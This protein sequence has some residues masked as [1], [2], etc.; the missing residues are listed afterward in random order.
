[1][2]EQ[3]ARSVGCQPETV[4]IAPKAKG[5]WIGSQAARHVLIWYHGGG[6]AMS[7]NIAYFKFLAKVVDDARS[8]GKD[9]AVFLV[10]YSLAPDAQY[11]IQ[12]TQS[13]AAL[14]HIL[15]DTGRTPSQVFLGGDSAGGNLAFGVLSHLAHKCSEI[16]ELTVDEPLAGAV[17]IAP[18]TNLTVADS[19]HPGE[20]YCGGDLITPHAGRVWSRGYLGST[21]QNYFTDASLAL[22]SWFEVFP[23]RAMLVLAGSNEIML[24]DITALADTVKV[25]RETDCLSRC[26]THC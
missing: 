6:F 18:W 20:P 5:H 7:A 14:R 9:V 12:L 22:A 2:Y 3:W 8:L 1:M 19:N 25:S 11:P 24:P 26:R 15:V 10:A 13:V 23:V 21:T 16:E 17:T 4:V